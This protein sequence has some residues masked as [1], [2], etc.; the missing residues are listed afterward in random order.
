MN[1]I[2]I[3]VTAYVI[4][5]IGQVDTLFLQCTWYLALTCS[6]LPHTS[7]SGEEPLGVPPTV[8]GVQVNLVPCLRCRTIIFVIFLYF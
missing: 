8:A 1:L 4:H 7:I 6:T 3:S 5:K 2:S